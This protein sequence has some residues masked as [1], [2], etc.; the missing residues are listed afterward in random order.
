MRAGDD[1][2]LI[3]ATVQCDVNLDRF[4]L[5]CRVLRGHA[6]GLQA[7]PDQCLLVMRGDGDRD[8]RNCSRCAIEGPAIHACSRKSASS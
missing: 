4:A 1:A 8:H 7:R 2:G 5:Q 6:D 3:G